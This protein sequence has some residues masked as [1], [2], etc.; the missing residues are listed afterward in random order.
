MDDMGREAAL[1]ELSNRMYEICE[2]RSV[3]CIIERKV[4]TRILSCIQPVARTNTV[5]LFSWSFFF[6]DWL[7]I[8]SA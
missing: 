7:A 6:D 1:Y 3:S 5:V 4:K 8:V 2:R